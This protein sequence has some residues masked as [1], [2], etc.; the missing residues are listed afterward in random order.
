MSSCSHGKVDTFGCKL[1]LQALLGTK[2]WICLLQVF[3]AEWSGTQVA[4]KQLLSL[5]NKA[6]DE[7]GVGGEAGSCLRHRQAGVITSIPGLHLLDFSPAA[8][9]C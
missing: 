9:V 5:K 2:L 7:V 1:G 6:K 3:L 4:A 8:A